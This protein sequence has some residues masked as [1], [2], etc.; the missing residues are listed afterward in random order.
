MPYFV[1]AT[2]YYDWLFGLKRLF[3]EGVRP[4]F[5]VLGLSP[6][7]LASPRFH[8]DYSAQYL[9]E[10][11]G[12]RGDS[13]KD[14]HGR[15]HGDRIFLVEGQ[16]ILRHSGNHPQ[17]YSI[18]SSRASHNC[19][20]PNWQTSIPGNPGDDNQGIGGRANKRHERIVPGEQL[21]IGSG[22]SPNLPTGSETIAAV[23]RELVFRSW[24]QWPMVYSTRAF[25]KPT[26]SI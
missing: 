4:R 8:G 2:E 19:F 17:L 16:Q 14:S 22:D 18:S 5:V 7:Q 15:N 12:S 23:G 11:I 26:A 9:F 25:T 24:F 13:A 3:A 1:L 6:N 10:A 21:T 20:K